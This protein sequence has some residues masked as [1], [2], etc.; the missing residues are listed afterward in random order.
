M[1]AACLGAIVAALPAADGAWTSVGVPHIGLAEEGFLFLAVVAICFVAALCLLLRDRRQLQKERDALLQEKDVVFNFLQDVG[2]VFAGGDSPDILELQRRVLFYALRTTRAGAGA[3]YLLEEDGEV[4]RAH[5]T[6]GIFPPIVGGL[7]EGVKK[8]FSMTK[9]VDELVRSQEA[10]VG[11]GLIGEVAATGLPLLLQDAEQDTRIPRFDSEFLHV[12][13]VLAVPMRFHNRVIGVLVVMNRVDDLP[14]IQ[15]DQ[16]LLQALADQASV[17]I[18]YARFSAAMD[19]KRR[20]DYD[21]GIAHRI[22]QALLPKEIPNVPGVELAAFSVP[23]QQI[24]G[25][26]YDF[27]RIDDTHIGIAIADVSGKGVSGAIVMAQCRSALRVKAPGCCRPAEVLCEMQRMLCADLAEDMFVTILYMVFNT[28]THELRVARAGHTSPVVTPCSG[29]QPWTV[30]SGGIAIGLGDEEIFTGSLEE[31]NVTLQSGDM[32]V[33]Y[34]DGVTE[35]MDARQ[36]EWGVLNL[37]KTIQLMTMDSEERSAERLVQSVQQKLLQFVGD[38]TQ[39]DD[40]TLVA[41][42]IL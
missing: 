37:V 11:R 35:A 31:R 36:N 33:V 4:L 32:L 12:H 3:I 27:I 24:G 18:Y 2:E 17:A 19:E 8:A 10:H 13:S 34:T 25:D 38:M 40:M 42:R 23:A 16:N 9:H 14:F 5:A 29:A 26:Y 6:S 1:D 20:L 30:D 41:V 22:Q 28:V 7:D 21:L 39:Y 15:A